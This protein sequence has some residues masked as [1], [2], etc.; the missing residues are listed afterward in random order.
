MDIFSLS[1]IVV[2]FDIDI[3]CR[4]KGGEKVMCWCGLLAGKIIIH[5]F[6]NGVSVNGVIFL[7]MLKTVG[8]PKL[9]S[10]VNSKDI[11][12]QQDGTHPHWRSEVLDW[13]TSKSA[14]NII[15]YKTA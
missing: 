4:I 3:E 1:R 11:T 12:F 7:E 8:W 13:L 15:S 2:L 9:R 6:E 5:C 14:D 10:Q